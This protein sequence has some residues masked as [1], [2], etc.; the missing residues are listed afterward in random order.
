MLCNGGQQ[1]AVR[2]RCARRVVASQP[3]S[4]PLA[5]DGVSAFVRRVSGGLESELHDVS[6]PPRASMAAGGRLDSSRI[7]W[8]QT[9]S[10]R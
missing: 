1:F 3:A 6:L 7:R 10:N 8:Q 4:A 2:I 9:T 5:L